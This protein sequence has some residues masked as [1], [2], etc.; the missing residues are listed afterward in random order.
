[1][2]RLTDYSFYLD[3]GLIFVKDPKTCI[4]F[5]IDSGSSHSYLPTWRDMTCKG[6]TGLRRAANGNRVPLF[7]EV[8]LNLNLDLN[9]DFVWTFRRANIKCA[10]IGLNFLRHYN[11]MIEPRS[12]KLIFAGDIKVITRVENNASKSTPV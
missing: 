7:E 4:N 3:A 10:V 1:V 6:Q 12:S 9:R 5:L 2:S 11:L 8:K